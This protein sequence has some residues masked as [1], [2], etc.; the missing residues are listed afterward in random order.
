MVH[1]LD[2]SIIIV[3]WKSAAFLRNC[4]A[5]IHA[6]TVDLSF[7]VIVVDNG[8]FDG[9]G[10]MLER[11][12]PG[13]IFI[14]SDDNLG[15]AG[16]NN[17]GFAQSKG[18]TV[19]FLNPDTE[20]VGPAL[21]VMWSFLESRADAGAVG[22][23]LLNSDLSIQTSCIQ[24]FPSILNQLLD[25][26]YLRERFPRSTLWGTWPL[27]TDPV[28][29]AAV[30][31]ITGACLMV[32]R[33][34]LENV[35]VFGTD[36]FMYAEDADLCYKIRQQGWQCYYV[37]QAVVVHHGGRSSDSKPESNFAVVMTRESVLKFMRR[38]KGSLYAAA[39][40]FTTALIAVGRLLALDAVLLLTAGK[41]RHK[42]IG[43]ALAKWFSI[44]RWA[45]GL[46]PWVK[47]LGRKSRRPEASLAD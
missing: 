12:F 7:E 8:S 1:D 42:S 34:V 5:S 31:V 46:E 10:E 11:E 3:N 29:P 6:N 15:F 36:Y 22:G 18:R 32:K 45:F 33:R 43:V 9:C 26:D 40:R 19:L 37:P 28:T 17:L 21:P 25:F 47:E 14:Q 30:D 13:T 2:L 39:Y 35:G 38:R 20:V 24:R 44:L 4:L 41:V 16:A 23:K 27:F